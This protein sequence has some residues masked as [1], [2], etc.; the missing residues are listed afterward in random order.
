ELGARAGLEDPLALAHHSERVAYEMAG[1]A[2]RWPDGAAR[3]AVAEADVAGLVHRNAAH[4]AVGR[5]GNVR[6]L[7]VDR[8]GAARIAQLV[9][10]AAR[11]ALIEEPGPDRVVHHE[12]LVVAEVA[13]GEPRHQA[14]RQRIQLLARRRLG[15]AA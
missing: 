4:P 9:P 3:R 10:A 8:Q 7:L 2:E 12:R 14:V 13:V 1:V 6:S 15:N 5:V 11:R